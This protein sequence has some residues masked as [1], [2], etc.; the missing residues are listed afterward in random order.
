MIESEVNERHY[1]PREL[2]EAWGLSDDMIR[3]LFRGE[4]GVLKIECATRP[5]GRRT[6]RSLR[7]PESVAAR[8]HARLSK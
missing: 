4:P 5:D 1:K 6:Y 3:I 2:A 7:I 8:V